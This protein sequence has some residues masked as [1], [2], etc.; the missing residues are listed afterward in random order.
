MYLYLFT[1]IYNGTDIYFIYNIIWNPI[2]ELD[3]GES[4]TS[5][6]LI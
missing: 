6:V 5:F 1:I 3:Y 4:Q 2:S